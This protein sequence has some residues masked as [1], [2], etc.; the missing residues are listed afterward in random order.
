M[1][2]SMESRIIF[3]H[4]TKLPWLWLDAAHYKKFFDGWKWCQKYGKIC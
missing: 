1:T 2:T 3:W 4:A